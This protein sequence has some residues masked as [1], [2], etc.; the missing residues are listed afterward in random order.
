MLATMGDV[1]TANFGKTL[2]PIPGMPKSAP[3]V[4][5]QLAVLAHDR[6]K[7][8]KE[9]GFAEKTL[10]EAQ[11]RVDGWRSDVAK[12]DVKINDAQQGLVDDIIREVLPGRTV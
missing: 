6:N 12:I 1:V 4:L 2:G 9:L 3:E 11:H 8:I 10:V 7:A 5:N